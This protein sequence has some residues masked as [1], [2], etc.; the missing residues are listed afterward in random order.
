LASDFRVIVYFYI[1]AYLLSV[2]FE[3]ENVENEVLQRV[4]E[5]RK[6]KNTIT[7]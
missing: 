7:K 3:N 5:E 4:K 1:S 6:F 2:R